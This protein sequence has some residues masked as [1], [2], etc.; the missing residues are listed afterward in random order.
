M[1]G[2]AL[3]DNG[4]SGQKRGL[5]GQAHGDDHLAGLK[6]SLAVRPFARQAVERLK[7]DLPPVRSALDLYDSVVRDESHTEIG[8]VRRDAA[9]ARSQ[10]AWSLLSPPR[11]SQPDPGLRLLQALAGS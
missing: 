6:H 10:M 8:R 11:A 3:S 2:L 1:F 9:L 5:G 4:L 7:R